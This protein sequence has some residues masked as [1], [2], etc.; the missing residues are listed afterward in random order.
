MCIHSHRFLVDVEPIERVMLVGTV[1]FVLILELANSA[2]EAVVDRVGTE[3]N[4]LSGRAKDMASAMVLLGFIFAG[5]VW[6]H[7]L[8]FR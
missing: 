7:L 3:E 2:I 8:V 5:F 6:L 4:E 1:F